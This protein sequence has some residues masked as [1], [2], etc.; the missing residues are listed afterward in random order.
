MET[1]Q[2]EINVPDTIKDFVF[3]LH[4]ATRRSY[5]LG[6]VHPLYE[7]RFKVISFNFF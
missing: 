7:F 1:K 5:R 6:D 4:D 2:N 3:D